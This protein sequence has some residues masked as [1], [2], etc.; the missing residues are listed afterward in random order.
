MIVRLA[1]L[2]ILRYSEVEIA[3]RR[4]PS[5]SERVAS[6]E[7]L[8][9]LDVHTNGNSDHQADENRYR[10]EG[11]REIPRSNTLDNHRRHSEVPSPYHYRA[12]VLQGTSSQNQPRQQDKQHEQPSSP[13]SPTSSMSAFSKLDPQKMAYLRALAAR[14]AYQQRMS[15]AQPEPLTALEEKQRLQRMYE[16][17]EQRAGRGEDAWQTLPD[18]PPQSFGVMARASQRQ[19]L[20]AHG[21]EED[22]SFDSPQEQP[23]FYTSQSSVYLTPDTTQGRWQSQS[24]LSSINGFHNPYFES[25]NSSSSHLPSD[26]SSL[27]QN[28]RRNPS[29]AKGKQRRQST[30]RSSENGHFYESIVDG[31]ATPPARPPKGRDVLQDSYRHFDTPVSPS[32]EEYER[33]LLWGRSQNS[34]IGRAHV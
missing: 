18:A 29:V 15:G 10:S 16:E 9:P 30:Y 25:P 11:S 12:P 27:S 21:Q 23:S 32:A 33:R 19:E 26:G 24:N 14:E 8:R 4:L 20:P 22:V 34:Q 17:E 1:I 7:D 5:D 13:I 6:P 2:F 3:D 31:L 28:Y